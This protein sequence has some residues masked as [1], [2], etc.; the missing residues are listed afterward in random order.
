[1]TTALTTEHEIE[2]PTEHLVQNLATAVEGVLWS[3]DPIRQTGSTLQVSTEG[4][5]VTLAGHVRSD[6]MKALAGR[7][8]WTVPGVQDVR[9]QIV[10]DPEIE[11]R[12]AIA[13]A[14]DPE[15]GLTTDRINVS[16]LL[17]TVY[18]S[19]PAAAP[20]LAQAEAAVAKA[21]AL[22]LAIPG[23]H[24]VINELRPVVAASDGLA[25]AEEGSATAAEGTGGMSDAMQAR[26]AVWRE[27]ATARGSP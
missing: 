27:R 9:N 12:A 24:G 11:S 25:V 22:V 2:H 15:V 8:A 20:D 18:L 1:M 14:M 10:A 4:G 16:S 6:M 7:L 13:L 5:V 23:V 21:R 3:Y 17:G 19:G 26:L